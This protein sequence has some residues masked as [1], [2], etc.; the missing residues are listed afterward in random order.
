MWT[1]CCAALDNDLMLIWPDW[2]PDFAFI[3]LETN[4]F[5]LYLKF[6]LTVDQFNCLK[7][8]CAT[9]WKSVTAS[10]QRRAP[11]VLP[12]SASSSSSSPNCLQHRLFLKRE[13][14]TPAFC[15]RVAHQPRPA[16]L[17]DSHTFHTCVC[18]HARENKCKTNRSC[19][20][21]ICNAAPVY[22]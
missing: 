7:L 21:T 5:L 15:P 12:S 19:A 22:F 14:H 6:K 18:F 17:L 9:G 16:L 4:L 10:Q 11:A 8:C 2:P 20:S 3:L 1:V 13:K